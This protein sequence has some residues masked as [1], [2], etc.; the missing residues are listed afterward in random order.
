M[1]LTEEEYEAFKNS[2]SSVY[3]KYKPEIGNDF[4]EYVMNQIETY[5]K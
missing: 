5:R 3:D 4:Y 1:E 2:V